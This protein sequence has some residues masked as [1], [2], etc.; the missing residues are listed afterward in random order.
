VGDLVFDDLFISKETTTTTTRTATTTTTTTTKVSGHHHHHHHQQ[1][2]GA[3]GDSEGEDSS[4][5]TEG[6][7]SGDEG[8]DNGDEDG[9][10]HDRNAGEEDEEEEESEEVGPS[11]YLDLETSKVGLEDFTLLKLIGQGGYGKVQFAR[12]PLCCQR[13][14]RSL[15]SPSHACVVVGARVYVQVYQVQKKD[16]EHVYAMKVLRKKHLITTGALEGTMVEREVLRSF[17]HPFIVSLHY[18]FQTEGSRIHHHT[19]LFSLSLL[20]RW[21][22]IANLGHNREG[23]P[24]DGLLEW[25]TAVLPPQGRGHVL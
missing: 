5:L 13:R 2:S 12:R 24:R 22:T 9:F 15:A 14:P 7:C 6:A 16:T 25:R 10:G 8:E 18:A 17:R 23:V 19:G 11:H 3:N 21:A 20:L 1:Q 4:S